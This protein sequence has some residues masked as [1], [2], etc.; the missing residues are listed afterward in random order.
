MISSFIYFNLNKGSILNLE[1]INL[2]DNICSLEWQVE[3]SYNNYN[4]WKEEDGDNDACLLIIN[5]WKL[6]NFLL[7]VYSVSTDSPSLTLSSAASSSSCSQLR[8]LQL[9]TSRFFLLLAFYLCSLDF[10]W[11][12]KL[13]PAYLHDMVRNFAIISQLPWGGMEFYL[14]YLE[15]YLRVFSRDHIIVIYTTETNRS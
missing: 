14:S 8:P 13:Y 3:K 5:Q 9:L 2:T 1:K 15:S 4:S 12:C 10:V 6:V 11:N 7:F